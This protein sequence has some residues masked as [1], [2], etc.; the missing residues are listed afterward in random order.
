MAQAWHGMAWH[1]MAWHGMAGSGRLAGWLDHDQAPRH[2][3]FFFFFWH[4]MAFFFFFSK[5]GSWQ[6]AQNRKWQAQKVVVATKAN[7][8]HSSN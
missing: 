7:H 2:F 4:G 8:V 1:G 6:V 3:F 5:T